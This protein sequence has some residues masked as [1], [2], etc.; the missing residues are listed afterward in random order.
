MST[1][2]ENLKAAGYKPTVVNDKLNTMPEL[3]GKYIARVKEFVR[4]AGTGETSGVEYDFFSLKVQIIKTIDGVEG[5]N[6]W[7]QDTFSCIDSEFRKAEDEVQRLGN[8]LATILRQEIELSYEAFIAAGDKCIDK[9]CKVTVQP[10]RFHNK[11]TDK[12]EVKIDNNGNPE[13][14]FSVVNKF[15]IK[16]KDVDVNLDEIEKEQTV[17]VVPF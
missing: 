10:K 4:K 7:L 12:W 1:V 3:K 9:L 11:E 13:H 2:F 17:G 5:K 8:T 15:V 16:G 6:R 14:K